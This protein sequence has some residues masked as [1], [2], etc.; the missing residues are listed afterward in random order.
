[1]ALDSALDVNVIIKKAAAEIGYFELKVEQENIIKQFVSGNDVFVCLP[2]GFGKSLCY[3]CLPL[4]FDM[5]NG[6]SLPWSTIIV[7]SPLVAL[8]EDQITSLKDKGISAVKTL[9][10]SDSVSDDQRNLIMNGKFQV[11]FTSPELLLTDKEWGDVF[12][13]CTFSSR[14][15]GF[16]VDEAHCVKKW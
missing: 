6:Q 14:L 4:V 15:V 7:V 5:L 9:H 11:I 16:I 3:S 10:S 1:M 8:M 12:Q 13:S 2:T